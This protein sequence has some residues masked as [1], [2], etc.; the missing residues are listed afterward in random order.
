MPPRH[1]K[2]MLTSQYFPA[3]YIGTYPDRRVIFTS[4][5]ADFAMSWGRKARDV[6]ERQ[7]QAFGIKV[8]G[9]SSA[10]IRW[11]V[12][13]HTGGMVTAGVGG[14]ITGKG[15]D[16][17]IIDDPVKNDEEARSPRQREKIFE[18]FRS[19]AYTRL[20][21]NGAIVLIM[22][23][24]H[25]EDLAGR[26]L[27][28]K[29]EQ[30]DL[31]NL[32]ALAHEN[33]PLGRKPGEALW[34]ARFSVEKL[35]A[36]RKT[37]GPYWWSCLYDQKPGREGRTEWPDE[38]FTPDIWFDDWPRTDIKVLALDPSKGKDSK[39]GD[40]SALVLLGRCLETGI[41]YCDADLARRPTS[42]IIQE[43]LELYRR[44]DPMAWAI[45]TN[46]FQELLADEIA[47]VGQDTGLMPAIIPMV[48]MVNK[49]VRIRRIGPYL[50]RHALRFRAG[51]PGAEL[52][53][54]QL[55]EF[56]EG[57][58]DDGPD[59]LEMAIRVMGQLLHGQEQDEEAWEGLRV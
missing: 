18:W 29:E 17:L 6:I 5:E 55:R 46:Q 34:P 35:Q 15:A 26:L 49:Q 38:Y 51:S 44:A 59:A 20:E 25:Q 54:Q 47:R 39:H 27:E 11:D 8:R 57:D 36:I 7:G 43:G 41:L 30:W 58:H 22:T 4:Y 2:S 53:V 45:E 50:A 14:P 19:T 24:W 16:L 48:N 1:G 9:D 12:D 40:Y 31:L 23:R 56:P 21:P 3:W 28:Q 52:L 37:I 42:R 32:S 13:G 33:D 10:A